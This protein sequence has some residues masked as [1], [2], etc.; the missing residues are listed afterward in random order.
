MPRGF[1]EDEKLKIRNKLIEKGSELFGRYGLKKTSIDDIVKAAGIAKGSFYKFFKT[2]E[3]LCFACME[4]QEL[5]MQDKYLVPILTR[6]ENSSD[7]F[8]KLFKLMFEM[9]AEYPLITNMLKKDEY[10]E[11]SR[12]LPEETIIAHREKD[13]AE[14][15]GFMEL[16]RNMGI[17]VNEQPEAINGMFQALALL[18]LHRNEIGQ[19]IFPESM[20]IL[21]K[22]LTAGMESLYVTG[23]KE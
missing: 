1:S 4:V 2:K 12:G 8:N 6:S 17:E 22:I 21:A 11:L 10:E 18:N 3:A 14:M 7:M 13:M 5:A 16:W 19:N 20:E 15:G 23:E 9:P